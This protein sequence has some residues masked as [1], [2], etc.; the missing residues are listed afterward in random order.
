[1]DKKY[2]ERPKKFDKKKY[3]SAYSKEHYS[4]F[5]ADIK[6]EIK[7]RIDNYCKETGISK[8][9]FLRRAIDMFENK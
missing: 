6:P 1:M 7:D 9:E 3:N 8:A 5:A 2:I 4:R